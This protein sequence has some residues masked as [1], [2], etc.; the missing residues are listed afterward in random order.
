MSDYMFML[1]SHLSADQNRAVAQVQAAATQADIQIFLVGG[2]MR[3][4]LGGFQLRDLDFTVEGNALKLVK[5]ITE[6]GGARVVSTDENRK[7]ADLVFPGDVTAE[8]SMARQERYTKVAGKPQ[9]TP[10][11]IQEDLRRR[12]FSIN[13]IALSLNRASRGLLLDPA[14]GLGDLNNRE[15]R[16]LYTYAFHDDPSRMLRLVRFRVRLGFSIQER[17]RMQFDNA[18]E[19]Q[20]ERYIPARMLFEELKNIAHESNPGEVLRA[21]EA[22]GLL[23]IFSPALA[24]PKLNLSSFGRLE[25]GMRLLPV[26]NGARTNR[27]G[28]FLCALTEKLT[29]KERSALIKNTDMR[30]QEVELWQKLEPRARKLEHALKSTRIKKPSHV[31]QILS[32]ASNDEVLFLL[33]HSPYRP[34]QDRI[35]NYLQKYVPLAQELPQAELDSIG[36]KPGTPAHQKAKESLIARWLDRRPRKP[37]VEPEAPPEPVRGKMR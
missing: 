2:A 10:A 4:M 26:E 11:S 12:D 25:R 19:A 22:E 6:K 35:R 27:L 16:A 1:E 29:P 31:Y 34:V 15:L 5:T 3:D 30:K 18:R 28:P 8:I 13:A 36:S 33:Y 14:N 7:L 20:L 9:V 23:Y 21:L 17:T 37:P 24:G 32:K